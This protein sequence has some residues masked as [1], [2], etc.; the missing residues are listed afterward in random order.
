M[1]FILTTRHCRVI[2][3]KPG[4][5]KKMAVRIYKRLW[6]ERESRKKFLEV[7]YYKPFLGFQDQKKK[8]QGRFVSKPRVNM[9]LCTR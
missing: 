4:I 1:G 9:G 2:G 3:T 7:I 8:Q 6:L 5:G